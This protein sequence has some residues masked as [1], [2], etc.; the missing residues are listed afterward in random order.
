[1]PWWDSDVN[2]TKILQ[3]TAVK[4]YIT[5]YIIMSHFHVPVTKKIFHR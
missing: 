2:E 1:M 5:H 4:I 3:L